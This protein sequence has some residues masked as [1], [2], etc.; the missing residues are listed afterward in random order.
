MGILCV[1]GG[2]ND[3]AL[4]LWDIN[5]QQS[6]GYRKIGFVGFV[7]NMLWNKL[8]GE[9]VVHWN[10]KE[11]NG[12]TTHAVITVL[13]SMDRLVDVV[14]IHRRVKDIDIVWNHDHTK[15]GE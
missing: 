12:A 9:L 3:G 7:K 2:Y 11:G 1:G 14:T 10:Y 4:S 6:I 13:A 15:L 8:S 5:R